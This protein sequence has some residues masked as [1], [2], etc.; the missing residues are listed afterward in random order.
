MRFAQGNVVVVAPTDY[1]NKRYPTFV[2]KYA[3]VDAV[4]AYASGNYTLHNE[5]S[6]ESFKLPASALRHLTEE[7]EQERAANAMDEEEEDEEEDAAEGEEEEGEE[8]EEEGEDG[9]GGEDGEEAED[10]ESVPRTAPSDG[11]EEDEYFGITTPQRGNNGDNGSVIL[12]P[13]GGNFAVSLKAGMKVMIIATDNVLQRV[14]HLANTIGIIKEAP[15]K[16]KG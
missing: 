10:D 1:A 4:P 5:E 15:G 2:G 13:S 3:I 9:D 16:L 6:G 11:E 7:Q 8:E 14:P 12:T